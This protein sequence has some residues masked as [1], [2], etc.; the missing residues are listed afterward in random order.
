VRLR[1]EG[2]RS[3]DEF[4]RHFENLGFLSSDRFGLFQP[5]LAV[6]G[7]FTL[8]VELIK[9]CNELGIGSTDIVFC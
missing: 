3:V 8:E 2:A 9:V 1:K 6:G 4:F 5:E 7:Q